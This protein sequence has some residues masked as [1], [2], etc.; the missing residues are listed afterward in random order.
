MLKYIK[1]VSF[2]IIITLMSCDNA[3]DLLNQYIENGPII[4]AAKID[5]LETQSGFNRFRVNLFP[6]EDVNRSYCIVSWNIREGVKDSVKI[7]YIDD[8]Y[9]NKQKCYY[10]I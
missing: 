6:A 5:N 8:N 9:D 7:D 4:Y 3:N 10:K 2:L 1:I